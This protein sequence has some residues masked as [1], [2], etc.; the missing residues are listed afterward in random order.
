MKATIRFMTLIEDTIFF[1]IVYFHQWSFVQ[2][3]DKLYKIKLSTR[4]IN[5]QLLC[6]H[7]C[8]VY[9]RL[10]TILKLISFWRYPHT[11]LWSY[12][13]LNLMRVIRRFLRH[14]VLL[15][16]FKLLKCREYRQNL[17]IATAICIFWE[18]SIW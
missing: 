11:H 18:I 4:K 16:T 14:S 10:M 7:D 8:F 12:I 5:L 3:I 2:G 17:A 1:T 15:S 9:L 13:W 6:L